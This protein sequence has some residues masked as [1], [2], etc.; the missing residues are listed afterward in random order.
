MSRRSTSPS[1]IKIPGRRRRTSRSWSR[2]RARSSA[3]VRASAASPRSRVRASR[4]CDAYS[5]RTRSS[6]RDFANWGQSFYAA[7]CA[8]RP[9]ARP[10][11]R[12]SPTRGSL[13]HVV[14]K[15]DPMTYNGR[16]RWH[17]HLP[18]DRACQCGKATARAACR[19]SACSARPAATT[20]PIRRTNASAA[21]RSRRTTYQLITALFRALRRRRRRPS[22][23]PR[24]RTARPCRA[25]SKV[26]ATCD[27]ASDGVAEVDLLVDN[28]TVATLTTA[29]PYEFTTSPSLASGSHKIEVACSTHEAGDGDRRERERQRR[30]GLHHRGDV[31]E[32]RRTSASTARASPAW[33]CHRRPRRDVRL[34]PGLHVDDVRQRTARTSTA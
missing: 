3:R 11:R 6:V 33:A 10:R 19:R 25:A 32:H 18:C 29:G 5:C 12:R 24:P 26:D 30:L 23:S 7:Q 22:R 14:D 4:Q 15:T 13:D 17:A 2:A 9:S 1:P 34:E 20:R 8:A 31:P 28:V 21:A 16:T 27:T